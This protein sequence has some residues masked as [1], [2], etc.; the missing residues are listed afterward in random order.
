M[1]KGFLVIISTLL[2]LNFASCASTRI[3]T[4]ARTTLD[5]AGIYTGTI[6]AAD[7]E[8]IDVKIALYNNGTYLVNYRYIGRGD[9]VYNSTGP[10]KWDVKGNIITLVNKDIPPYYLVGKNTLTQLDMKGKAITGKL[11]EKYVLKKQ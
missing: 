2:L 8:G 1:N 3:D 10:F 7:C 4:N 9:H 6:P 5:W 11:A